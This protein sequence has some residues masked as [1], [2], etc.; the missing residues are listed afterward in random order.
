M[1]TS[2]RRPYLSASALNQSLLNECQDNLTNK[3]EMIC[4][5]EDVGDPSRTLYLSDRAKYV[6]GTFYYPRV[7]FPIVDR[8]IGDW[9]SNQIE[10][11]SL[12]LTI[13]N[14]DQE[15]NDIMPGG[16]AY[17]G[18]IGKRVTVKVGLAE[19]GATYTTIFS[20]TVTEVA[21]FSRDTS[22]FKITARQD[23]EKVNI[24]IPQSVFINDDWSDIEESFIGLGMPIVYGDWTINLRPEAP[25][26]PAYPVNGNDV[27]VNASLGDP[28]AGDTA[29]RC[30]ISSTPIKTL[31]IASITLLRG[32]TYYI[33]DSSDI[34]IVGGSNNQ[35]FDITQ[36][37]LLIDGNPWIYETSDEIYVKCQGIDLSGYDDNI[38]AQAKDML[39]R[40]SSLT[41]GDFDSS[42]ATYQS[43]ASP[44]E[45]AIS[46]I[47]SRVWIQEAVGV[48][49]YVASMMEQVRLEP[50]VNRDNKFALS[51]LHFD[52]FVAVPSFTVKNWDIIRGSFEPKTDDGNNFNRSSADYSFSPIN[53]QNR[54]STPIYRN[55]AAIDQAQREISKIVVFPNLYIQ[56]DVITQLKEVLKLAS[57]YSEIITMQLTSRAFL[58]E[59]GQDVRLD[60]SIG[61]VDFVN[62]SEPVT[63]KIR[64][65]GYDP[66]GLVIPVTVWSFQLVPFPG[67]EKAGL[68]G[69]VG[70]STATIIQET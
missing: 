63:G 38:V 9:L 4:T 69:I 1:G 30:V 45:S 3:L 60:V 10:F 7:V 47:K 25:E 5:I 28:N 55:Q 26:V 54:Y 21:G 18:F 12:Q 15:Y 56:N 58:L 24:T 8:T 14:A 41:S 36:K 11:S 35:A 49:E 19:V 46:T 67:S 61:S 64:S 23:F 22:S 40:F 44:A 65:I 43:K 27:L 68:S 51:S 31:D 29:L 62:V 20:G 42:W 53:G 16:S 57:A 32:D 37:N 52:D 33:F 70:G 13:N 34:A 6:D 39:I 66:A 59:L 17:A 48:L 50:Y 2:D